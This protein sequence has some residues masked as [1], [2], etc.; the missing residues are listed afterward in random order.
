MLEEA[1]GQSLH[2]K[3]GFWAAI[4][5]G[6]GDAAEALPLYL[7]AQ[8]QDAARNIGLNL[9]L[10]R[11]IVLDCA[12]YESL[13]DSGVLSGMTYSYADEF[14][15]SHIGHHDSPSFQDSGIEYYKFVH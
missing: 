4:G 8:W 15:I 6:S 7:C 9:A 13:H 3:D 14:V 2:Q 5:Y 11:E 12:A 10:D 1:S